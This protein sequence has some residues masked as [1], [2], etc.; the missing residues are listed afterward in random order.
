MSVGALFSVS[1]SDESGVLG[2][3]RLSY[4]MSVHGLFPRI[5]S[6]IHKKYG[7]PYFALIIQGVIAF[8]LSIFSGLSRLISFSVFNLAFSFLLTSLSLL[9][10]TKSG[11]KEKLYGEKILPWI[12][13]AICVYLIYATTMF[14]KIIGATMILLGIPLYIFFTPKVEITGMKKLLVSEETLFERRLERK[15]RFLG[16]FVRWI[17]RLYKYL[18]E[19]YLAE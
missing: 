1:G 18:K 13:V 15:E 19:M 14:D 5:F 6:K 8:A 12:G 16:N 4:A 9:L 11:R 17:H 3:A 10:L 2:T 7:T